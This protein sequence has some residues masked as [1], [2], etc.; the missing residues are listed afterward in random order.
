[1]CPCCHRTFQALARHIKTKH[2][3]VVPLSSPEAL[4]TRSP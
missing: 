4:R 1:V 2:P 3:G